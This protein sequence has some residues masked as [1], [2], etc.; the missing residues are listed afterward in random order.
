MTD[1]YKN[2]T[3]NIY[4]YGITT[5]DDS[6]QFNR[7]DGTVQWNAKFAGNEIQLAWVSGNGN[8]DNEALDYGAMASYRK[9]FKF[10]D[11]RITPALAASR[12][13]RQDGVVTTVGSNQNRSNYGGIT[14]QL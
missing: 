10:G 3:P 11:F 6:Y 1:K 8:S 5:I 7:Q 4:S 9:S 13:K 2:F 12:Y 14:T